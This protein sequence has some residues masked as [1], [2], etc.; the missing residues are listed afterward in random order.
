MSNQ[1][2]SEQQ[3]SQGLNLSTQSVSNAVN[4]FKKW[5]S[6]TGLSEKKHQIEGIKWC[7]S[8]ELNL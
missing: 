4:E 6:L 8:R 5:I 3:P 1:E 7:L 2:N